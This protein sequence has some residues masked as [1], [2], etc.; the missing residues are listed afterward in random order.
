MSETKKCLHCGEEIRIEAKKC[1]Y[2]NE[3]LEEEV[4]NTADECITEPIIKHDLS[5]KIV[6]DKLSNSFSGMIPFIYWIGIIGAFISMAYDCRAEEIHSHVK[7]LRLMKDIVEYIPEWTAFLFMGIAEVVMGYAL[8]R[9]MQ[10]Q[11]KP[12]TGLLVANLALLVI[13][14]G[15]NMMLSMGEYF[16]LMTENSYIFIFSLFMLPF[17]AFLVVQ[18]VLLIQ[19]TSNYEGQLT[20]VVWLLLTSTVVDLIA[21]F[22]LDEEAG[23]TI[24]NIAPSIINFVIYF[25][26]L[27]AQRTLLE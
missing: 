13:I 21:S 10:K 19:I 17:V 11:S 16:E 8:L 7:W 9:G 23:F 18:I 14:W 26:C 6:V 20:V 22:F 24:S 5:H 2:C 1:K 12:M 15:C 25:F 27:K 4:E 3:W